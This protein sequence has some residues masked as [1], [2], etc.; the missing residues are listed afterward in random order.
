MQLHILKSKLHR[1][2]L[3]ECILNYEGSIAI[4]QDILDAVGIMPHEKLLIVNQSNGERI[5]TYA[6]PSERGSRR[7]CL[8]G[9]AARR[10]QPGDIITVMAFGVFDEKD[11]EAVVP[12]VAILDETNR[13]LESRP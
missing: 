4:D 11:A 13:I 3:T 10:G 2:R 9:A 1:A 7:F 12:R 5:E 6:I 8:N